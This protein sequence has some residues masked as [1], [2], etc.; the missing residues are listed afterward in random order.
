LEEER[1]NKHFTKNIF[2]FL[3]LIV[4]ALSSGCIQSTTGD[5]T[6]L[7]PATSQTLTETATSSSINALEPIHPDGTI[8][9]MVND[10]RHQTIYSV[11]LK[12]QQTEIALQTSNYF[13]YQVIDNFIYA[14]FLSEK[15]NRIEIFKT[16]L[17]GSG[18]EQLTITSKDVVGI[19]DT[20]PTNRYLIYTVSNG[21]QVNLRILDLHNN[22][23]EIIAEPDKN[24]E[25]AEWFFANSWSSDG[26]KLIYR[27]DLDPAGSPKCTLFV[28]D[29][30]EKKSTE[31]LP[32][33][34]VNCTANW[35]P[36]GKNIAFSSADFQQSKVYILNLESNI[37]K[38]FSIGGENSFGPYGLMWSSD[39]T[40]LLFSTGK[41]VY[42]LNADSGNF[43]VISAYPDLT[44]SFIASPDRNMILYENRTVNTDLYLF[45]MTEKTTEKI[46]S[47]ESILMGNTSTDWFYSAVWS[48]DGKY[49]GYFT[50]TEPN[51][52]SQTNPRPVLLNVYSI[53]TSETVSIE[54]P[55]DGYMVY[56]TYWK[57]SQ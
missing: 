9:Y 41:I 5:S 17:D 53:E 3:L 11:D 46:Y 18:K 45:N 32:N 26:K 54:V 1:M 51:N 4:I 56:A 34:P 42:L 40:K 49:F 22:K 16:N 19:F 20:D 48:P 57:Q 8:F 31:L 30:I 10:G 36:D 2:R 27:K 24:H 13:S 12:S 50:T 38:Q 37:L 21:V 43:E 6:T 23:S 55:A 7:T 14:T 35:S 29:V 33:K 44:G 25:D 28:Y 39:G 15:S 47:Q 52:D